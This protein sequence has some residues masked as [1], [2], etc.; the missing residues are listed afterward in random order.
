MDFCERNFTFFFKITI[1]LEHS[2][3]NTMIYEVFLENPVVFF[4]ARLVYGVNAFWSFEAEQQ[5]LYLGVHSS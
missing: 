3:L 5:N 2:I 1:V 4:P